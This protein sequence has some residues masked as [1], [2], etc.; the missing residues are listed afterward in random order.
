MSTNFASYTL[1]RIFIGLGIDNSRHLVTLANAFEPG[2]AVVQMYDLR[3]HNTPFDRFPLSSKSLK[4]RFIDVYNQNLAVTDLGLY[5]IF[6]NLSFS[7]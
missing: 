6:C 4:P 7:I 2:A 5:R 3:K 1:K